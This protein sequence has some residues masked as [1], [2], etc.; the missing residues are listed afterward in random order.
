MSEKEMDVELEDFCEWLFVEGHEPFSMSTE[1]LKE[2]FL[3]GLQSWNL[4]QLRD[5][6]ISGEQYTWHSAQARAALDRLAASA[7]TP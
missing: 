1:E 6:R 3:L 5:G 2:V 7:K 4:A